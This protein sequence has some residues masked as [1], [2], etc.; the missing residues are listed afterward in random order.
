[1]KEYTVLVD[2]VLYGTVRKTIK[3]K[4]EQD[5]INKVSENTAAAEFA[6]DNLDLRKLTTVEVI[7]E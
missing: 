6:N 7:E 3:A 5:A 4:S 2:A 1:M